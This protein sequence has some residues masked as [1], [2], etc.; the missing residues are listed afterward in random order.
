MPRK[1][2]PELVR[3]LMAHHQGMGLLAIDNALFG[4][5]MQE[6]FHLDRRVQA[7]EFLLQERMP[8]LVETPD[9]LKSPPRWIRRR[10][11]KDSVKLEAPREPCE[12]T[13]SSPDGVSRAVRA[14]TPER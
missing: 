9:S 3:C 2:M 14:G 12:W 6:R 5:R 4:G 7:T 8:A 10:N 1:G 11:W 13:S